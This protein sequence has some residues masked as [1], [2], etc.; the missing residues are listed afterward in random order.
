MLR[1]AQPDAALVAPRAASAFQVLPPEAVDKLRRLVVGVDRKRQ[2][3]Q[4]QEYRRE[5]VLR[6]ELGPAA[7]APV[8]R[9]A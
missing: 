8:A 3:E 6:E 2:P 4:R 7:A 5:R 9:L 1:G